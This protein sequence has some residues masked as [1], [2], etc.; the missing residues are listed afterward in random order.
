MSKS[1]PES[2]LFLDDK[3]ED[4]KRKIKRAFT[5]SVGSLEDHKQFGGVPEACSVFALQQAFNP[6]D[7]EVRDLYDRYVK[8]ELLMGEL[9]DRTSEMMIGNLEKFGEGNI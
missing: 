4:I 8:G 2:A 3:P 6:D 7:N 1:I 9:K 5:G